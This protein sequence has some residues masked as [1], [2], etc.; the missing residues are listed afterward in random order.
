[1]TSELLGN[2]L[3]NKKIIKLINVVNLFMQRPN[4]KYDMI[5]MTEKFVPLA[6][7]SALI[8]RKLSPLT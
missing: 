4:G 7:I 6:L 8:L 2:P 3:L 5:G 1:M